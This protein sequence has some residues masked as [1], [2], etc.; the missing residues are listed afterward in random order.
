MD[1]ATAAP[2]PIARTVHVSLV[3]HVRRSTLRLVARSDS[4]SGS[5][6]HRPAR[7][8]LEGSGRGVETGGAG[9]EETDG[10][11]PPE[12]ALTF[13]FEATRPC[14]LT[15]LFFAAERRDPRDP[16]RLAVLDLEP[17]LVTPRR[18]FPA[19]VDQTYVSDAVPSDVMARLTT[20]LHARLSGLG[21]ADPSSLAV[22]ASSATPLPPH[23]ASTA[24]AFP[25]SS[26][27]PASSSA[28][29]AT[30]PLPSPLSPASAAA[31][32]NPLLRPRA[33]APA[34]TGPAFALGTTL[35]V[36]RLSPA[37]LDADE[38]R[39]FFPVLILAEP[40]EVTERPGQVLPP[41]LSAVAPRTGIGWDSV[42]VCERTTASLPRCLRERLVPRRDGG[43][44]AG[45]PEGEAGVALEADDADAVGE[46]EVARSRTGDR[47]DRSA[48][49]SESPEPT[50]T[51]RQQSAAPRGNAIDSSLALGDVE[52]RVWVRHRWF[53][54]RD[55]FGL[56]ATANASATSSSTS[57][58][59][60]S[61][62]D[63]AL[64]VVCLTSPRSI[65][66]LPCRHAALCLDCANEV[67]R[68]NRQCPVCREPILVF[69][70]LP[71]PTSA[72]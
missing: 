28:T 21:A 35:V 24:S 38:G 19:G 68:R 66:A 43:S 37:H 51:A 6:S 17:V 18:I 40:A 16:E 52:Q 56:D 42:E 47:A 2:P 67:R 4:A 32:E 62:S 58:S 36:T 63:G 5:A 64:C 34:P 26:P 45:T 49:S 10:A 54:M 31:V 13:T 11:L 25:L 61:G 44:N 59:V 71:E 50:T 46:P 48:A 3:A 1:D 41:R 55:V 14:A 53:E 33:S 8:D 7:G 30:S 23:F 15:V 65:L 57:T 22:A 20:D 27:V 39:G 70:A 9:V 12:L 29:H 69:L 60:A 72:R